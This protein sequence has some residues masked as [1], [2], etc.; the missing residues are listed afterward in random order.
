LPLPLIAAALLNHSAPIAEI[1]ATFN[2]P[3]EQLLALL[4]SPELQQHLTAQAALNDLRARDQLAAATARAVSRL[5][6]LADQEDPV[7]SRR[8]AQAITRISAAR[9]HRHISWS[10]VATA[11][12][13]AGAS[14]ISN[15]HPVSPDPKSQIQNPKSPYTPR[16]RELI[17]EHHDTRPGR[18]LSPNQ[19]IATA[20]ALLKDNDHPSPDAGLSTLFNFCTHTARRGA[21]EPDEFIARCKPRLAPTFDFLGAQAAPLQRRADSCFLDVELSFRDRPPLL[22]YFRLMYIYHGPDVGCWL[23]DAIDL[24]PLPTPVQAETPQHAASP[25]PIAD[26]S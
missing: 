8:A 14:P 4:L 24:G 3:H 12:S 23:I 11:R 20:L 13:A 25:P 10:P 26:T 17:P 6:T 18:R 5:S 16:R 21:R 7:E 2:I 15:P 1:A 9:A 22:V 19:V